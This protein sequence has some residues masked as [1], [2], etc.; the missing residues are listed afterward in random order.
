MT[1][2]QE[3]L[4][5]RLKLPNTPTPLTIP[6]IHLGLYMLPPRQTAATVT[7]ALSAGY[8]GFDSAQWYNNERE[9]GRAIKTYLS[10]HPSLSRS[11][12]FYTTKL[13]DN[14][15][16][17]DA[18]RASVAKSIDACGLGYVDL[19]LLHSPLG[20]R[21]ARMTSYRALSSF[22]PSGQI[23]AVGV[24]N[25]GPR[26]LD[27]LISFVN[28]H[29]TSTP[30]PEFPLPLPSVNQ[31]EIHPFNTQLAIRAACERHGILLEAYAPL[32]RGMRFGHA[33]LK[34]L[35]ARYKCT[36]AQLLVRWSIQHGFV[37]LPKSARAE[38]LVANAD[39]GGF[40]ISDEDMER[41][42]GLD[43]GLVTDWDPTDAP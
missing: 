20:G 8:R 21:E 34:E 38:R 7:A 9:A 1:T 11:D 5:R 10:T 17:Y 25:F 43:E 15:T 41:L 14:S 2:S 26:H 12:V 37:T 16:S 22:L 18:V 30:P 35:S 4:A 39:V 42:D 23:R 32:A 40:E 19:F 27:E 36:E 28:S 24:S 6:Q 31:I 3:M 29:N 13:R 33:V